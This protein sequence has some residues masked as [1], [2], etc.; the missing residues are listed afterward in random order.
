MNIRELAFS[1]NRRRYW[2]AM[3]HKAKVLIVEYLRK[4]SRL[5]WIVRVLLAVIL[6]VG[7]ILGFLPVLGFWMFPLGLLIFGLCIPFTDRLIANWLGR[8]EAE[9]QVEAKIQHS[10]R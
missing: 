3:R 1:P 7:G 10:T 9:V 6:C 8:L 2:L 5:P 4:A